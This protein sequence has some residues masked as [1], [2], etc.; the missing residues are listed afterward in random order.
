MLN[1]KDL[2]LLVKKDIKSNNTTNITY[3]DLE[4]EI[5][6]RDIW[7]KDKEENEFKLPK[8]KEE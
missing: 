4:A 8:E 2:K 5:E 7:A 6:K 1:N 3:Q